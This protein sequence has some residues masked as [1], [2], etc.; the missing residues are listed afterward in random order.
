M[1]L[2]SIV[3]YFAPK[4]P[5]FS[6]SSR[7]T[8]T[9]C[10]TGTDVMAA[11]GLVNAKCGF[12]FDLYLA[13]IGISSPDRA[14]EALYD[15]SVEISQRFK[16]VKELDEKVRRRVLEIMCA[17]AYQ[18]YARSAA[19]VRRCDCCDGSGFTEVEVFTNKI[20]YPDGKPPKWAKV[21]KGVFPSYWEE[22]KSV[23]ESARVL[24]KACNGKGVISN[25]CR[26]HGKGMVLDKEKTDKQGAPVM[27]V[28]DRC[29]GRGYA[30]LKF[31]NVLEGVR[32]VWDVKKTTAYDHVQPLFELLVEECHRQE[33]YADSALKS[34]T[35]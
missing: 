31:S 33:S 23:R 35:K 18:D 20:Q 27:K 11:L 24:C 14:M 25:A 34:V 7:A 5:M 15:S 9:D 21:A 2:E 16:S 13:K 22:W 32:T 10:L 28:C 17:F 6:D 30:R 1:N 8:A 4:S 29:T 26:C 19:S 12:G 3:K